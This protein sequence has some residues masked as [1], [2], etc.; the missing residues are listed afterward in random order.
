MKP[1]VQ[2]ECTSGLV[3]SKEVKCLL[4]THRT[5]ASLPQELTKNV[6]KLAR[7]SLQSVIW[8]TDGISEITGVSWNSYEHIFMEYLMTKQVVAKFV[9]CLLTEE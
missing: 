6:E 3:V 4:K 5:V 9:P 7:L 1:Q 2:H 8:T